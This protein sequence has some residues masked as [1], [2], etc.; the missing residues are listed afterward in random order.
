MAG[1]LSGTAI[2]SGTIS[3]SKLDATLNSA[4][5]VLK[6][7]SIVYP[8]SASNT[9]TAGNDSIELIGSGFDSNANVFIDYVEVSNVTVANSSSLTFTTPS[10]NA[11]IYILQVKNPDGASIT[12]VPGIE[13]VT[14]APSYT[15]E[16]TVSGYTSGGDA[17]PRV[18]TVDKF[19]FATNSNA[20][21]V[22]NLTQ[23]RNYCSGQSS[24]DNGY[25]SSGYAPSAGTT[26]VDTIDKFSFASD[27]NATDVGDLLAI[28]NH[29]AGQ[30]SADNGYVSGGEYPS[31][32]NVIQKFPFASDSNA[33]D[34]GDLTQARRSAAGQSSSSSG[35]VA[36]GF[37]TTAVNVVDKF[38]FATN[39]NATD[40][41]DLT[42]ARYFLTGQ[43]SSDNGYASGGGDNP[44]YSNIIDKF[45]FASNANATDVGDLSEARGYVTGQSSTDN[46]YTSGGLDAPSPIYSNVVDK[47]PFASDGN[48]TDVGDL[49]QAR[50]SA[51]GQQV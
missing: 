24:N 10:Q 19:S 51:A 18:D 45:P 25:T 22:G 47:F 41:G 40:V 44:P 21:D 42:Q 9:S 31:V 13:Y 34:V 39:S 11:G 1:K 26:Y 48:A 30:S 14:P 32:L 27:G 37:T 12:V 50:Y 4:I 6:V 49:T 8:N 7:S 5:G 2:E 33:T 16:G 3:T 20:T 38:P 35:Y 28:N 17:P 29:T 15:F 36:G 23:A 46:G 43:S